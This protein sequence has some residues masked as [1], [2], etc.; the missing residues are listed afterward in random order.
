MDKVQYL[1]GNCKKC[2]GRLEF[3]ARSLGQAVDCPHCGKKTK[4]HADDDSLKNLIYWD[5]KGT[6]QKCG[7]IIQR[8]TPEWLE[9]EHCQNCSIEVA[10]TLGTFSEEW[11]SV[12]GCPECRKPIPEKYNS[13]PFCHARFLPSACP[14]CGCG[15]FRIVSPSRPL[16]I[17]PISIAGAILSAGAHLAAQAI[18]KD[19]CYCV[20]CGQRC[21]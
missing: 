7:C 16:L 10:M 15:E 3:P 6:C 13:C 2:K 21:D 20:N 9:S 4:L 14:S 11:Q 18:F 19:E 1:K 8:S 17:T 5:F 12:R